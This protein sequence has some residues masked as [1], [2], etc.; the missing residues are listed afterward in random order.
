MYTKRLLHWMKVF[1]VDKFEKIIQDTSTLSKLDRP[2]DHI[3]KVSSK[4]PDNIYKG[5]N[6]CGNLILPN[7][8]PIAHW[9][10]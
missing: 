8:Q 1:C 6:N 5:Q 9:E 4:R 2:L 10:E 7:S 3:A